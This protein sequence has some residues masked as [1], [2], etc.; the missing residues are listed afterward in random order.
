MKNLILLTIDA[1]RKDRLGCYGN[2][3]GLTPFIDSLGD[4]S[5]IF[6]KA[7]ACG[8]YTQASFPGILTSSYFMDY[9][10]DEELSLERTL[11]S[12]PLK[13]AGI[14][15]AAFHSNLYLSE[16]MGW[17]RS[18]DVFYDSMEEEVD[19]QIPYIRGPEIIRK[20]ESWLDSYM[21]TE[22][23]PFFAWL[24]FMDVHEPYVP[25]PKYVELVDPTL[26]L[27][28]SEMYGL[29]E[30]TLLKRDVSDESKVTLL[31]KLYDAHVRE[32]DVYVKK[33]FQ[34]LERLDLLKDSTVII[35]SDHGDEFNDHGSLSHDDKMYSELIDIPLL[36]FDPEIN[37][38]TVCNKLV[39][40]VDIPPTIL[41][42][43]G[44]KSEDRFQGH[45]LFPLEE[46]PEKGCFGEA[47]F[48]E[49]GK[50]EDI[51]KDAYFY[52]EKDVKIIYRANID[53]WEM[54]DLEKDPREQVNIIHASPEADRLKS[55]LAARVRSWIRK[56]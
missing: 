37:K 27:S 2:K 54:F 25:E 8:P 11:I 34:I 41:Y 19:P 43:F 32:V 12:E 55:I 38:K 28:K 17:N 39:S 15:T 44:I 9:G 51:N 26:S 24:H 40:N 31:G 29:F 45:S 5:C 1:L 4:K 33:F 47:L 52:R 10:H 48:H 46:Y 21:K 30:N 23:K 6:T 35:T 13:D 20:I 42:L 53:E 16:M 36:V 49:A 14:K 3:S 7:Q 50:G 22:S 18:W 56:S